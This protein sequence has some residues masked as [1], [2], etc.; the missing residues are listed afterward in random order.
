[1]SNTQKNAFPKWLIAAMVASC[2]AVVVLGYLANQLLAREIAIHR[3][4]MRRLRLVETRMGL[5]PNPTG[6][7]SQVIEASTNNSDAIRRW[8]GVLAQIKDPYIAAQQTVLAEEMPPELNTVSADPDVLQEGSFDANVVWFQFPVGLD[9]FTLAN[10]P[11]LDA[12][13]DLVSQP[14]DDAWLVS[15]FGHGDLYRLR[16]LV[17][18]DIA[19][20]VTSKDKERF[21]KALEGYHRL[22]NQFGNPNRGNELYTLECLLHR[23]L[24][25]KLID[26]KIV[27]ESLERVAKNT[28]MASS[29]IDSVGGDL[30]LRRA[31]LF[32][33]FSN[34]FGGGRTFPS[35]MEA[36]FEE[37][38]YRNNFEANFVVDRQNDLGGALLYFTLAVRVAL[39]QALQE[40]GGQIRVPQDVL[41]RLQM[42]AEIQGVI[43]AKLNGDPLSTLFDY[44]PK[45]PGTGVLK[46]KFP[47]DISSG[48]F[49]IRTTYKIQ[50]D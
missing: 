8:E 17:L 41:S 26:S 23:G 22:T 28:A 50:A 25:E 42:P 36:A 40:H 10:R 24:D 5:P 44:D 3:E 34:Q 43:T 18:W 37:Y 27:T 14:L 45:E 47:I 32:S 38:L 12:T 1:M 21:I 20:C 39:L 35:I 2:L 16:Q 46:F 11:L 7:P 29:F 49:P 6:Q 19:N 4:Q 31:N 48:P 33:V 13:Y 30:D 15:S 9:R